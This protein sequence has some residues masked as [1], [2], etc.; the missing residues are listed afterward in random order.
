[1]VSVSINNH[2]RDGASDGDSQDKSLLLHPKGIENAATSSE[3]GRNNLT[4]TQESLQTQML[5]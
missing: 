1:M 2:P 4:G 5:V 3:E